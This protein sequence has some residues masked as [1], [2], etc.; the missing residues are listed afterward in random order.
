MTL[1]K[2]RQGGPKVRAPSHQGWLTEAV[3]SSTAM[4]RGSNCLRTN[5]TFKENSAVPPASDTSSAHNWFLP[6]QFSVTWLCLKVKPKLLNQPSRP[7]VPGP[8][9]THLHT[10]YNNCQTS[11]PSVLMCL[12]LGPS[13]DPV[14][15]LPRTDLFFA[16]LPMPFQCFL[17]SLSSLSF[18]KPVLL[19]SQASLSPLVWA[20]AVC[21]SFPSHWCF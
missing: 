19:G 21:Q 14:R 9:P 13:E 1:W 5:S 20:P 3:W 18:G 12:R 11:F 6:R 17:A 16:L 7:T 8:P 15:L 10:A 2:L 4:L